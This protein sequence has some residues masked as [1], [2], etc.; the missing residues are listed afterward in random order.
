MFRPKLLKLFYVYRKMAEH[1]REKSPHV[2]FFKKKKNHPFNFLMTEAA[3]FPFKITS[4]ASVSSL[5]SVS[6]TNV[7]RTAQALP[8]LLIE[9][10]LTRCVD[11]LAQ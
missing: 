7:E 10:P 11:E 1:C 3:L 5:L 4:L 6:M 9:C 8:L 2:L